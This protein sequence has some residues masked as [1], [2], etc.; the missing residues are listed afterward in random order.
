MFSCNYP[1]ALYG[2]HLHEINEEDIRNPTETAIVY[3]IRQAMNY[4]YKNE[5]LFFFG[6]G[7]LAACTLTLLLRC[8]CVSQLS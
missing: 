7:I 5:Q 2:Q 4:L 8:C 3:Y 6:F 1:P